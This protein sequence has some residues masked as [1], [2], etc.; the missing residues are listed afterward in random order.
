MK[1]NVILGF[2]LI[3]AAVCGMSRLE[4]ATLSVGSSIFNPV[5]SAPTGTIV[6]TLVSPF[7]VPGKYSGTLTSRVIQGDGTNPYGGLTF[8][9]VLSNDLLSIN[10]LTAV[11]INGYASS[12]TDAS[13]VAGGRAP[14][15][16]DRLTADVVGFRFVAPVFIP[17]FGLY[18]NGALSPGE[19]SSRLVIQTD[20]NGYRTDSRKSSTVPWPRLQ[21]CACARADSIDT[22]WS[23]HFIRDRL[24]RPQKMISVAA[25]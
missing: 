14:T 19:T 5:E 23:R 9:Y 8:E 4:A 7:T 22:C 17:G 20:L 18:G 2:F 11:T 25:P 1:R 12:L 13:Y 3:G 24:R 16:V 21:L 15:T 6:D 10:P